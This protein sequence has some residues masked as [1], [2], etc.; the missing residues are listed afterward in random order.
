MV[1]VRHSRGGP[2]GNVGRGEKEKKLRLNTE[3]G[4]QCYELYQRGRVG[5]STSTLPD[6]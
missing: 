5:E 3:Y 1:T 2:Y 4:V 6:G